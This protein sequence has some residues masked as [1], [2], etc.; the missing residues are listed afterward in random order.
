M[1]EWQWRPDGKPFTADHIHLLENLTQESEQ[2]QKIL[3]Q[4]A[5][6]E[7]ERRQHAMDTEDD[8]WENEKW[9][10]PVKLINGPKRPCK[11]SWIIFC[12]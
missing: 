3:I 7:M 2:T 12:V 4:M 1:W 10:L 5:R 11:Y 9:M 8:R 6:H